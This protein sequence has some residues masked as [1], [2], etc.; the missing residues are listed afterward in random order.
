[1]KMNILFQAFDRLSV[2][3]TGCGIF[4]FWS[5]T[6]CCEPWGWALFRVPMCPWMSLKLLIFFHFCSMALENSWNNPILET[7][8]K[9][10]WTS[11][12]SDMQ[13]INFC[14]VWWKKAYRWYCQKPENKSN[15]RQNW[16]TEKEKISSSGRLG[17]HYHVQQTNLQTKLRRSMAKLL[18]NSC[19]LHVYCICAGKM[20]TRGPL[21]LPSKNSGTLIIW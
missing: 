5:E 11:L 20:Y 9:N 12:N 2:C 7:P 13:G 4:Q 1:M 3:S 16:W 6:V 19:L 18:N 15:R 17:R 8:R 10:P 21:I 14:K